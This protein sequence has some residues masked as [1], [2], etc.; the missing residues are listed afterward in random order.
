VAPSDLLGE[1]EISV[2]PIATAVGSV[3]GVLLVLA[4]VTAAIVVIGRWSH[5][6]GLALSVAV[7][8]GTIYTIFEVVSAFRMRSEAG[9]S[10]SASSVRYLLFIKSVELLLFLCSLGVLC[11]FML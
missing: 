9:V 7:V 8:F 6:V 11:R 5:G 2:T 3:I 1:I 10:I 4:P